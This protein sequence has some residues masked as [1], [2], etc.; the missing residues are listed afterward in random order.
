MTDG[1][2]A[3]CGVS[4]GALSTNCMVQNSRSYCEHVYNASISFKHLIT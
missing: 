4:C 1:E 2:S 3:D